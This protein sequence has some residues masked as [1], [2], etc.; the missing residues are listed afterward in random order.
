MKEYKKEGDKSMSVPEGVMKEKHNGSMDYMS[1][2]E[3]FE[4]KDSAKI[5]RG[6]FKDSRY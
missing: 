1:K 3:E 2:Q 4:R 5:Q 6:S